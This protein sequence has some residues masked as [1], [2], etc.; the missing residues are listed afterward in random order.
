MTLDYDAKA[1]LQKELYQKSLDSIPVE[2]IPLSS[3]PR[4]PARRRT[5]TPPSKPTV[6]MLA[7]P[8]ADTLI[9]VNPINTST[10]RNR[11]LI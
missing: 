6:T 7:R 4:L 5:L 10:R 8:T 2:T 3:P 11:E 1:R 9:E